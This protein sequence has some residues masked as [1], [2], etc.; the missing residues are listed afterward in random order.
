ME[1]AVLDK[2]EFDNRKYCGM[3]PA[4]V[5]RV[6]AKRR[7]HSPPPKP[8]RTIGQILAERATTPARL[9]EKTRVAKLKRQ[10]EN[11]GVLAIVAAV[12]EKHNC[13][14]ADIMGRE[15]S[16]PIIR[17]R[18]EAIAEVAKQRPSFSTPRIGRLFGRDHTTVLYVLRKHQVP[19]RVDGS[20]R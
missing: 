7:E 9:P 14:V 13:T 20:V 5:R 18:H 8:A 17:A 15:L 16:K 3:N 6:W 2:G 19:G 4:F 1:Q 10:M 11:V 12:A